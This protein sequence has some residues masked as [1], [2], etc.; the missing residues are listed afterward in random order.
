[1]IAV[2]FLSFHHFL[3]WNVGQTC[4]H[5]LWFCIELLQI[6]VTSSLS[7]QGSCSNV[8]HSLVLSTQTNQRESHFGVSFSFSFSTTKPASHVSNW[9]SHLTEKPDKWQCVKK[10]HWGTIFFVPLGLQWNTQVKK[11]SDETCN[12][13]NNLLFWCFLNEL[14]SSGCTMQSTSRGKHA[15]SS[16]KTKFLDLAQA[17]LDQAAFG[18]V[19]N[20]VKIVGFKGRNAPTFRNPTIAWIGC[21]IRLF[22]NVGK[23]RG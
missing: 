22:G 2:N 19:L 17:S 7:T 10:E 3:D 12:Q 14:R 13:S 9:G 5:A 23:V 20:F 11:N 21:H 8:C 15:K 18:G 4:V 1:M 6:L 16:T